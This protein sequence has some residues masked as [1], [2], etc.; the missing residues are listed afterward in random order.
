QALLVAQPKQHHLAPVEASARGDV[1]LAEGQRV[2]DYL[3]RGDSHPEQPCTLAQLASSRPA[4]TSRLKAA[5]RVPVP[6]RAALSA[7]PSV[8]L[9]IARI[10]AIARGSASHP[11]I[12]SALAS[13]ATSA[14]G[15]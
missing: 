3:E 6:A 4:E 10:G 13:P 8:R 11:I 7:G 1:G 9:V 12:G 2:G 5:S 15:T 14:I